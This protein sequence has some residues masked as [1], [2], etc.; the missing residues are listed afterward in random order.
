MGSESEQERK[1]SSAIQR[2]G[3]KEEKRDL[4]S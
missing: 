1:T 2:K 4:E 3:E